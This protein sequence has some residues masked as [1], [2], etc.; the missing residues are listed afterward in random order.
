MLLN[1]GKVV[2]T[3]EVHEDRKRAYCVASLNY[4][5]LETLNWSVHII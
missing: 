2:I 1:L 3:R 4:E 5:I